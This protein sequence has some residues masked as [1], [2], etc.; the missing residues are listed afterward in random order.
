MARIVSVY[1]ERHHELVNMAYIRWYKMSEAL[2]RLGHQVDIATNEYLI[3]RWEWWRRRRPVQMGINLRR[4]PLGSVRWSDYDVVK[5]L[6]W[7]GFETLEKHG[8]ADHPF[9]ISR[10]DTVLAPQDMEGVY[11]CGEEREENFSVQEKIGKTSKYVALLNESAKQLWTTFV[12]AGD[13]I[14]MVPGAVDRIIPKALRDPYPR[15][16][17]TRCLFA[18]NIFD[19]HFA[20][21]GNAILVEKLNELGKCL[22]QRGARLYIVGP[23]DA[24]RL[25]RRYLTYLGVVPYDKTWDYFYFAHVGIE[26]VKAGRFHH[27]NESS[28][29]YHYLRVGL[30]P[31]SEDG[32]P[33]NDLIKEAKLGFVVENGNFE[34]MA[35]KVEEAARTDWNREYAISFIVNNH[36]WDKRAEVYDKV[37]RGR[38]LKGESDVR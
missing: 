27:H 11:V 18:G 28:K 19:K 31:V 3:P 4:V 1:T 22:S 14:L 2:A 34:L 29:L 16:S 33:N 15:D 23:G 26:L 24:R 21:K 20:E 9:I 13:N 12:G 17:K 36:T 7:E 8:G 38:Q 37:I 25:D 6:Y 30:P 5:T 35:Q 32:L 10:L